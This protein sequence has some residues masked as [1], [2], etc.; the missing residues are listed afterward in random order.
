LLN[1]AGKHIFSSIALFLQVLQSKQNL[2]IP[3]AD[4]QAIKPI[5][6]KKIFFFALASLIIFMGC[7][8]SD[9]LVSPSAQSAG[10][11]KALQANSKPTAVTFILTK[12]SLT[13]TGAIEA[14]GTY[15]MIPVVQTGH[16]FHCTNNLVT[17]QGT[18]TALT[19][20][21]DNSIGTWRIVSGTGAYANLQGN[22]TLVMYPGGETWSGKI[23]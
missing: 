11:D 9:G 21:Y 12:G 22:G 7:K 3:S 10:G 1:V 16:A 5:T 8:K 15:T 23:F 6:M 17:P 14:S 19:N 4:R 18:I 13:I 20:C 2:L